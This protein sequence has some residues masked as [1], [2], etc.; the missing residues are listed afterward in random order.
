ME[1]KKQRKERRKSKGRMFG[2][3]KNTWSR[4]VRALRKR[5]GRERKEEEKGAGEGEQGGGRKTMG[6][7]GQ[8]SD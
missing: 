8:I 2:A 1:N 3:K 4:E 6:V 7:N 5:R